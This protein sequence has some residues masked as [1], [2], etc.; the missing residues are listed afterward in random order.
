MIKSVFP[1]LLCYVLTTSQVFALSGGPVFGNGGRVVTTGVY[2]GVIQGLEEND[3]TTTGPAIPGDPVA[4][5]PGATTG[6]P[7]NALG[8]FSLNVPTTQLA[9]GAFMLFADG[10]VFSGTINGS[11]DPDNG[12]LKGLLEGTFNFSLA[13]QNAT[14]DITNTTVTATAVGQLAAQVRATNSQNATS[15]ARLSGTANLDVNFGQ[16]S[17]ATLAPIIA[18]VITFT[19]TG[20]KQA[21][22]TTT[23]TS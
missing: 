11:V 20:F 4:T 14:G 15:L 2:S 12:R 17:T 16:V 21:E 8:L 7:S 18:R 10:E 23:T 13:T 6:V 9:T 19:V 5:P 3:A 22:A 1:L